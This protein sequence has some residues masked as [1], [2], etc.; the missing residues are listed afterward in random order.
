SLKSIL[1]ILY[2]PVEGF[3]EVVIW[4]S[5]LVESRWPKVRLLRRYGLP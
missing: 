4:R 3:D 1:P 5:I 2:I